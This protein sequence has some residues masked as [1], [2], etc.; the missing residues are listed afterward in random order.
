MTVD[1]PLWQCSAARL[2]SNVHAGTV[3]C[4]EVVESHLARIDAIN[5]ALGAVTRPLR[6]SAMAAAAEADRTKS[7]RALEGVAFTAKE[8]I[9]CFGSP[10]TFG[11]PATRNALP[12]VD[13]PIIARMK[14]AGAIIIGRTNLSEMSARMCTDNPLHGRTLSPYGRRLTVGGSS[15]GDAVAVATGM[16]PVGLGGDLGG[17]LRVPAACCG[18]VALKPTTGRIAHAS[19]LEPRDG[20]L[21]MQWM[22]SLGPLTRTVADLRLLL[23]VVS[24]RDTRDPRSVDVPIER[25]EP[26]EL[27]AALVT[28][29][30]GEPLDAFAVD[31]V[32]RAGRALEEAGWQ[33]EEVEPP[34]LPRVYDIFSNLL[35][36]DLEE[37]ALR[38]QALISE[39]L[40]EHLMRLCR[41]NARRQVS[42]V[43]LCAERSRLM[44]EWAGF[45]SSYC[46]VIGPTL[47]CSIWPV[48]AD[49]DPVNGIALL[50]RATRFIAPGSAL[51]IPSLALPMGLSEG[52]PTS[53][54][55]H[56]DLW[57]EDLCMQA[58]S[59]VEACS[60]SVLP[61]EPESGALLDI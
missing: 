21:A 3:T 8:V 29:L 55:I 35:A 43:K 6:D 28:T 13:A 37:L 15:G 59:I 61:V 11:V 32:R 47:G 52:R 36:L 14:A 48:D 5:P 41:A 34:E 1:R 30:P 56:A 40:F 17:S 18:C 42:L 44:R 25:P 7:R 57:R 27:T 50:E 39:A 12:Y 51:G 23:P 4:R 49:L 31:A 45:F 20:G 33:V 19:S 24:G 46:V 26:E 9:D 10:T 54:L 16:T 22:F 60:T 38:S 53:V 58:G 2:V